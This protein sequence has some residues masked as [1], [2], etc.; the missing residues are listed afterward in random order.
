M[1]A[2]PP[3]GRSRRL[4]F[5]PS[6]CMDAKNNRFPLRES[7]FECEAR[8]RNGERSQPG[9]WIGHRARNSVTHHLQ[10]SAALL[11]PNPKPDRHRRTAEGSPCGVPRPT[12]L[13]PKTRI[14]RPATLS[15]RGIERTLLENV[16]PTATQRPR[17]SSAT[18]SNPLCAVPNGST[19]RVR[20]EQ[21]ASFISA[22]VWNLLGLFV[23]IQ[24]W[25]LA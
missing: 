21:D 6:Q 5:N 20:G 15:G 17:M 22:R 11:T 2:R 25:H 23:A 8:N 9:C 24:L 16:I 3:V 12:R 18:G 1:P 4:H 13:S 14:Q 10:N 19:R 7:A